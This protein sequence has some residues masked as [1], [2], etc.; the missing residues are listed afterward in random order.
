LVRTCLNRKCWVH[1][2]INKDEFLT[3]EVKPDDDIP[4]LD[5]IDDDDV[6]CSTWSTK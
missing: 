6:E 4:L 3:V 2:A 1:P 5:W